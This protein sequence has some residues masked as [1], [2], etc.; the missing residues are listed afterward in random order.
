MS[1]SLP[2]RWGRICGQMLAL[3][4]VLFALAVSLI[5]G[6]LPQLT[7]V[8][9]DLVDYLH[10]QYQ[11]QVQ[12][13]SLSAEW[14]AFGPALTVDH[15]VL[16]PQPK[17]PVTLIVQ[18]T[19]FKLD[20][21]QSLV[22]RRPQIENVKFDGVEVAINLDQ[23][24]AGEGEVNLDW[25][26]RLLLEQLERFAMDRVSIQLLSQ[27]HTIRPIFLDKLRWFN[28]DGRHRAE[29][30]LFL[31]QGASARESLS[32]QVD[33]RG[34]GNDPD[35]IRGQLYLAAKELDL[36]AWASHRQQLVNQ[37]DALPMNGVVNL[38][39]WL[40]LDRRHLESALV[41]FQ[42]SHLEWQLPGEDISQRFEIS[43][44]KL[45]W[46]KDKQ[47]GGWQ[48]L[49]QDLTL[50][51]NGQPW[52]E[53]MLGLRYADGDLAAHINQLELP[54]L[55][56]L[57]V[58]APTVGQA[59]LQRLLQLAPQGQIADARVIRNGA[60]MNASASLRHLA[61]QPF[62]GI[63]G[64][65]AANFRLM[66]DTNGIT[67][68]APAQSYRLD[69]AGG[70]KA[71]LA[72]NARP[73]KARVDFAEQAL[74]LPGIHLDN[75]DIAIDAAMR[76]G[77]QERLHLALAAA[78][79]VKRADQA[80]LYFPR[81]AMGEPLADYLEGAIK[82]GHSD[83]AQMVWHGFLGD[84]PYGEHQGVFQAGFSL[85]QGAY[86]FQPDWPTVTE[87]E[88]RALFE[89]ARMDIWAD[90]GK[91]LN[92]KADGAHV[93][94]PT[95]D[96]HSLLR[97]E[98]KL[99]T[100]GPAAT[101]VLKRSPLASSVG[102]TLDVV[103]V[104]GDVSGKLDLSIPL[105]HG[106]RPEI[107]GEVVFDN[108][109]VYLSQPGV[110]LSRVR[111]KVNF[112]NDKVWGEGINA[113]LFGQPL[114]FSFNSG[115]DQGLYQLQVDLN[116]H[117]NLDALP[118]ELA[119]PL[120]PFYSG[121]LDWQGDLRLMFDPAG[122]R[123]Q[124]LV[125]TE[126]VDA[127]LQL[128]PPFGKGAAEISALRAEILGDNK[129][130]NLGIRL[131]DKGEFWGSFD[132]EQGGSGPVLSHYDLLLGRG[133]RSGD[134]LRKDNGHLQLALPKVD[135]A[136]WLPLIRAFVEAPAAEG[137]PLFPPLA[138]VDAQVEAMD[139]FGQPLSQL[140]FSAE[141]S[142][143]LWRL[144]AEADEFK[145]HVDFFP[146]W[147]TGGL[148]VAAERLDLQ[149]DGSGQQLNDDDIRQSLPPLAVNV[150][151]LQW[152]G[153]S[154]GSLTLQGTPD[155][156][157]YQ[158]QTLEL[159]SADAGLSGAGS[160]LNENGIS[161]TELSLS[162]KADKF[163][164][165]SARLGIDPG[166]KE[167]PL[168]L[169]A[170][171]GWQGAPYGFELGSLSGEVNFKLGKGHMS[172][173]SDKGARIFSLFSLDSLLRKLSLDFSD[174][175]GQGLY[176]DSFGGNLLLDNGVVKTTDTVMDAV[177]G[178]MKVRGY[179]DLI[180]QS[181]NYDIRFAPKLASS[182][183]TVVL[184]STSAWTMGLGAFALTKVLEPVIE[185]ISEIRFRLTGTM[186]EPL[187]EEVE[188][189]SKEIEIPESVLPRR[190][191]PQAVEGQAIE[192]MEDAPDMPAQTAPTEVTPAVTPVPEKEPEQPEPKAVEP[193]P[194]VGKEPKALQGQLSSAPPRQLTPVVTGVADAS[195][196]AAMPEQPRCG[197]QSRLYR[198][199][200]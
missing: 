65:D 182:V 141:P 156:N 164:S 9:Q 163:D 165:V 185:V 4:L 189:K 63:P 195:Q 30:L 197:G 137:R 135:F 103:Q 93:Y 138:R 83:D 24:E 40:D 38:Q 161:Q 29:G 28:T 98:A 37:T 44:G 61:W 144:D 132:M 120:S 180:S 64:S 8:R 102:A 187:L 126:L 105:W 71:P 186:D 130:L 196:F 54:M 57:A 58:L 78:V 121:V 16:P 23:L 113:R 81:Q 39:A 72:L 170:K 136:Q 76:L 55:L 92:V 86:A 95:M 41:Q 42:P 131:E 188:R 112:H 167:A 68:A 118:E 75:D 84:F 134:G 79:D 148:K 1:L 59:Q 177:A 183:P 171:L 69:F 12:L 100:S 19:E 5:R 6:L 111:G 11:V 107:L 66:L 154:L 20:F 122:F 106:A 115:D 119:N 168:D 116:G 22:N 89:N 153:K 129:Q 151:D 33:L 198:I 99:A 194:A 15:L 191:E 139:L 51:S 110:R 21:W 193:V 172:Q 90:K 27:N 109:P 60:G 128:P 175:F 94:I 82:A 173:L 52:P 169:T 104:L 70:F 14:Q 34:D 190:E 162:L 2:A 200:A 160:W 49:S 123:I 152:R 45:L 91:L 176:F 158:I 159:T 88:V 143:G 50:A 62:E 125:E 174:V 147:S 140:N 36:G 48:L 47:Q 46:L 181:L 142:D 18:R 43:K 67:L 17:L 73:F 155:G 10:E 80:G 179:T 166:I 184:L 53:L 114:G 157:N 87:L 3:A 149:L 199:A 192:G 26:Y 74:L 7:Q 108:T 97:V 77:W 150:A 32:L 31:Q 25:L 146:D 13:G 56:P 35:S 124:G 178:E 127:R 96:E 145:G 133:F 117:W 85:K 101:A